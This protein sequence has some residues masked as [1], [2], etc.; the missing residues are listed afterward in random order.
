[1]SRGMQK[2]ES[3]EYPGRGII[4]GLTPE[5]IPFGSYFITGR[6]PS[7]KARVMEKVGNCIFTKPTDLDA[8]KTGNPDLLIYDSMIWLKRGRELVLAISN[9]KQTNG[10]ATGHFCSGLNLLDSTSQWNYEPDVPNFTSRISGKVIIL[11][12]DFEFAFSVIEKNG[13]TTAREIYSSSNEFNQLFCRDFG[14]GYFITTY[15]GVNKDPLPP[16]N[17]APNSIRINGIS[18]KNICKE[19]GDSIN[20][21]F[22]VS[23]ATVLLKKIGPVETCIINYP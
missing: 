1:M 21:S 13:D 15:S 10:I 17:D 5:G 2:L 6:S 7:S 8:L 4:M 3:M 23:V 11:D 14:L 22:R 20:P 16:F 18:A 19:I 9:G 12:D